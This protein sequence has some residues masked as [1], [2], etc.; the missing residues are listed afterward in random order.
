MPRLMATDEDQVISIPGPGNF[1][2]SGQRI[3]TLGASEYTLA[4]VVCDVSGSVD[5]FRDH[6][7]NA[8]KMVVGACRK[9]P[10]ADNLLLRFLIFNEQLVEVH[11][12]KELNLI[13]ENSYKDLKPSGMTALYDATFNAIGASLEMSKQL[14]AQDFFNVNACVY[15]I[16][17]GLD[18]RSKVGP[19]DIFKKVESS[20]STE[21]I[22]SLISVLVSLKDPSLRWNNEIIAA[23]DKFKTQAGI[24]QFVD[25]GDATPQ[26]LAKLANFVSQ[27]ISSQSQALG[28]GAPSQQLQ[29]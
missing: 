17:D 26:R 28:S 24:D 16:T 22:E 23:L 25:I 15:I 4:S 6:L 14:I 10:R 21:D 8:I 2:F 1:Q 9:S 19:S 12:F 5:P 13:D 7:L 27:S 18:N 11:G 3:E 20:K 29:F